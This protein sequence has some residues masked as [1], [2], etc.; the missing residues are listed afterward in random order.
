MRRQLLLG[1]GGLVILSA[2][3]GSATPT[4]ASGTDCSVGGENA[5]VLSILQSWYYWYQSLP[6]NVNPASYTGPGALL[7]AVRQQPLDRFSYIT[8]QAA[9]QAYYGAGQYVGFGLGFDFT[10]ANDLQVTRVFPGSPAAQAGLAR[11][12]T[13]TALNGTPVPALAASNQLE[14]SLSVN[15][16]GASLTFTWTDLSQQPHTATLTSAVVTEPSVAQVDVIALRDRT[17]GYLVFNSFIPT[18]PATDDLAHALGDP[19][20]ASLSTALRHVETGSCGP[21]AAAAAPENARREA[22][23]PRSARRYEFRRLVGAY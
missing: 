22:A 21:G 16:P 5:Q 3:A 18:C 10:A 2:C 13:V 7:D 20:E 14:S 23:H 1:A 11:G 17:V 19:D 8:S 15:G 6:P 9:D 4:G 12:D